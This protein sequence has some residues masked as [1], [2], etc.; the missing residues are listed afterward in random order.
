MAWADHFLVTA[1]E[2]DIGEMDRKLES[3][4][5]LGRL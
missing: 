4:R 3:Q 5:N 2:V 1:V